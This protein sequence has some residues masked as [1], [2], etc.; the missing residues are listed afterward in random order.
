MDAQAEMAI[1]ANADLEG[2]ITLGQEDGAKTT[3]QVI[4]QVEEAD[5][6]DEQA[7]IDQVVEGG[8]VDP[9]GDANSVQVASKA[10]T[11]N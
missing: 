4:E 1:S 2:G 8:I 11:R 6:E 10:K 5:E 7:V 3:P 9:T